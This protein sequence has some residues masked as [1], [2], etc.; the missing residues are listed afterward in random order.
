MKLFI[1]FEH[2]S[3]VDARTQKPERADAG[4]E[5]WSSATGGRSGADSSCVNLGV[6][7]RR[8]WLGTAEA[9]GEGAEGPGY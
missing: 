4:P 7:L 3:L 8:W 6:G 2:F 5:L 1:L 9:E